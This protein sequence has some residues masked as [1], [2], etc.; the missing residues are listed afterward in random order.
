MKLSYITQGHLDVVE[1]CNG[2][3]GKTSAFAR[4]SNEVSKPS[5]HLTNSK[6]PLLK[7]SFRGLKFL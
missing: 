4:L 1:I 2:L 3:Y 5:F 7:N 6:S